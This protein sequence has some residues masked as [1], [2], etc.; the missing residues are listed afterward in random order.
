MKTERNI[1]TG[2]TEGEWAEFQRLSEVDKWQRRN[3]I[4]PRRIVDEWND[5]RRKMTHR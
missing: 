5:H 1:A 4:P 3:A 2:M